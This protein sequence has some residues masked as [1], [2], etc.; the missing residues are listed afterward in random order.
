MLISSGIGRGAIMARKVC[1]SCGRDYPADFFIA[2]PKGKP[3]MC[4]RCA[5]L[6]AERKRRS[7]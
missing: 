6:A 5:E 2:R 4:K 1:L 3:A 7:T